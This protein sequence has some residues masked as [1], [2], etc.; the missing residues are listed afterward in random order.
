MATK[1][2]PLHSWS[3]KNWPT[4]V[5]PND[6]QKARY[7][8]RANRDELTREGALVR[9]GRELVVIGE[10]YVRW[11]QKKGSGVPDYEC[12]ANKGRATA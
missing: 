10:R 6:S 12:P 4:D 2:S 3:I 9:V 11:M 1:T 7:L 5:Y 8:I